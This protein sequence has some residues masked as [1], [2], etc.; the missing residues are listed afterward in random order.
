MATAWAGVSTPNRVRF[1]AET[2]SA[3][4]PVTYGTN[5]WPTFCS[6][7]IPA[8]VASIWSDGF[9]GAAAAGTETGGA[10]G[11]AQERDGGQAVTDRP[12]G[13]EGH[14][15]NLRRLARRVKS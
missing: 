9:F 3:V 4:P 10:Q 6:R 11:G 5:S 14:S 15:S 12:T 2:V 13:G 7:V 8:M 1:S